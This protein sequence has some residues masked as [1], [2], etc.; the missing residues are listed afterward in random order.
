MYLIWAVHQKLLSNFL[1]NKQGLLVFNVRL[2]MFSIGF[3][4]LFYTIYDC[5]VNILLHPTPHNTEKCVIFQWFTCVFS[6][7]DACLMWLFGLC[8][9]SVSN[10]KPRGLFRLVILV[11]LFS[12]KIQR[13]MYLC[14]CLS[15]HYSKVKTFF[16]KSW[17]FITQW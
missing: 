14:Q 6:M 1:W 3:C 5:T 15:H 7:S 10:V 4:C 9:R 16:S 2:A 8:N 11:L 13:F 17:A 12:L